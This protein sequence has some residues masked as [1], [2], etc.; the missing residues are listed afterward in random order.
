MD[1]FWPHD[2]RDNAASLMTPRR[3]SDA[4]KINLLA[5]TL[6][7]ELDALCVWQHAIHPRS[8]VQEGI[9]ISIDRIQA[10]LKEVEHATDEQHAKEARS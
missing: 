8:D 3:L 7:A 5:N 4:Q 6:Q 10:A 1:Y 2:Q 9:A